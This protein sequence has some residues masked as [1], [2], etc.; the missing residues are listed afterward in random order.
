MSMPPV[1]FEPTI[2]AG[3]RPMTYVL[4]RAASGIGNLHT[5]LLTPWSR[6]LLEKLTILKLVK[7]SPNFMKPEGL[8]PHSQEPATCLY[9]EPDQA[10]P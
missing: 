3:E 1:G 2:A 9:P 8:L 4:D 7:K 5:Y 10:S 6:I